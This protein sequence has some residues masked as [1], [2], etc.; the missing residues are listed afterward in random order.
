MPYGSLAYGSGPYGGYNASPTRGAI[1][2]D[3]V[4]YFVVGSDLYSF[5]S[6]GSSVSVGTLLTDTG[7]VSMASDGARIAIADGTYGYFY[8]TTNGLVQI[9]DTDLYPPRSVTQQDGWMI[10]IANDSTGR[11][12]ITDDSAIGAL[13]FATASPSTGSLINIYSDH[14]QLWLFGDKATEVWWNSGNADFTFARIEG[15]YVERGIGAQ[16][17]LVNM[18]STL[19]WLGEDLI[20]YRLDGYSPERV[21]THAI[22][23][24][25]QG[26]ATASDARAWTHTWDGH[27]FYVISFP[28]GGKTYAFDASTGLWARQS[29]WDTSNMGSGIDGHE[30]VLGHISLDI[31]GK[32]LVGSREDGRVYSLS[33][34]YTDNDETIRWE[35]TSPPIDDSLQAGVMSRLELD[36]EVGVSLAT[37]QGSDSNVMLTVSHDAGKTWGNELTASIGAMGEFMK[38]V[39]WRRLGR[40]RKGTVLRVAGSDP[41]KVVHMGSYLSLVRNVD[42]D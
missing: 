22:E 36:L 34:T 8:D 29:H 12:Q 32:T 9:T 18:D 13:D 7:L 19:Y 14:R 39:I 16:Y 23:Q 10:F 11:F 2:L 26:M 33:D 30:P 25:L 15:V 27:K 3:G 5:N 21:S 38:Q 40:Y 24:D 6:I 41:V 28:T 17:S 1:A 42:G 20:I 31:Y 4:A 37:G 35:M